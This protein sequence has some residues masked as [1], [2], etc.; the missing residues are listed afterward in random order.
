MVS[1][2]VVA[3]VR[4]WYD[5]DYIVRL[6]LYG[7]TIWLHDDMTY[8]TKYN[9]VPHTA[10]VPTAIAVQERAET[11]PE[12]WRHAIN[13]NNPTIDRGWEKERKADRAEIQVWSNEINGT[14]CNECASKPCAGGLATNFSDTRYY[15]T[16]C[17]WPAISTQRHTRVLSVIGNR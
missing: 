11:P 2:R 1:Q 13:N 7:K 14:A 10:R 12:N 4:G 3:V 6:G 17:L 16:V 9:Q 5:D 8:Q 15:K